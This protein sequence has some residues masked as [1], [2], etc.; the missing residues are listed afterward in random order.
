LENIDNRAVEHNNTNVFKG[1]IIKVVYSGRLR[2]GLSAMKILHLSDIHFGIS[3]STNEQPRIAVALD[4]AFKDDAIAPDIVVFSGDLAQRGLPNE[5]AKGQAWLAKLVESWSA[6]LFIV[7]GNHDVHRTETKHKLFRAVAESDQIYNEWKSTPHWTHLR[8]FFEWHDAARAKLPIPYNWNDQYGFHFRGEIAGVTVNVIGLNSAM[9]SCADDDREN[10]V[11]DTRYLNDALARVGGPEELVIAVA[12]HPTDFLKPWNREQVVQLFGQE[13]GVNLF[14][15]GDTHQ[16]LATSVASSTGS[17]HA[18]L[19]AGATYQ[20]SPGRLDCSSYTLDFERRELALKNY[21]FSLN[22]GNWEVKTNSRKLVLNIPQLSKA[23]AKIGSIRKPG[24]PPDPKPDP[25]PGRKPGAA[26]H[27]AGLIAADAT[28]GATTITSVGE[29]SPS[30]GTITSDDKIDAH[31]RLNA[32]RD[33]QN[34]ISLYFNQIELASGAYAFKSRVKDHSRVLSKLENRRKKPSGYRLEDM[35][36]LCAFRIIT[37]YQDDIPK[38]LKEMLAKISED[39]GPFVKSEPIEIEVN[40]SRLPSDPLSLENAVTA[41]AD[42]LKGLL[43]LSVAPPQRRDTG[44]SSIHVVAWARPGPKIQPAKMRVEIQIRSALEDVWGEIDHRLD[45]QNRRGD[46]TKPRNRHLNVFKSLI[47]ALIS[48]VDTIKKAAALDAAEVVTPAISSSIEASNEQIERLSDLPTPIL[49]RLRSAYEIWD[50]ASKSRESGRVDT[51]LFDKG[52]NMFLELLQEFSDDPSLTPDQ[53]GRFRRI[54]EGERAYLL[55]HTGRD[56]DAL[57]S[58]TIYTRILSE[59][60]NSVLANFRLGELYR[61][62]GLLQKS[63]THLKQALDGLQE[64]NEDGL[65]RKHAV[66]DTIRLSIG[67]TSWRMFASDPTLKA[68]SEHL[69]QAL[70]WAKEVITS[71]AQKTEL[72]A[73]RAINDFLYYCWEANR[74]EETKSLVDKADAALIGGYVERLYKYC[75]EAEDGPQ[76]YYWV[77]TVLRYVRGEQAK[78]RKVALMLEAELVKVASSR[79]FEEKY[80]RGSVRWLGSILPIFQSDDD[81]KDCLMLTQ[82]VLQQYGRG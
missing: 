8:S 48:Y 26:P 12:H 38:L 30:S 4:R 32:A 55:L 16:Q 39:P 64:T 65:S 49:N 52:A 59:H 75:T 45:F 69:R 22:S 62:Q 68:K 60:P 50:R 31:E 35:P 27:R 81:E 25:Q 7:P 79:G 53:A 21:V 78:A 56:E 74:N 66:Y 40:T 54:C 58:E 73:L 23:K 80:E 2:V 29:L 14:L 33:L 77:D 37:L 61:K 42:G 71:S 36:D 57:T 10:L 41:I 3:D 13:T 82:E 70:Q 34:R 5:F 47:D 43:T 15:H 19:S 51:D 20:S 76:H 18:T 72:I 11:I 63:L 24:D 9:L 67:L 28:V 1:R 44:Y 17:A 6:K 46:E